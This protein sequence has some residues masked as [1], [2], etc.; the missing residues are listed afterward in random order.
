MVRSQ[1]Q[2]LP[3][4]QSNV[5]QSFSHITYLNAVYA[6]ENGAPP[7]LFPMAWRKGFEWHDLQHY[8]FFFFCFS[9]LIKAKSVSIYEQGNI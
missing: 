7:V 5:V 8:D 1:M 4:I 9:V 3:S 6:F 2:I